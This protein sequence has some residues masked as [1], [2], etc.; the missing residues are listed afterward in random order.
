MPDLL[1]SGGAPRGRKRG[2][3]GRSRKAAPVV[4]E[5]VAANSKGAESGIATPPE[6]PHRPWLVPGV[7]KL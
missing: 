2:G 3:A 7:G 1:N 5:A 4:E 6:Q